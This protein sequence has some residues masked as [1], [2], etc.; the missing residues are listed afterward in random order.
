MT[1]KQIIINFDEFEVKSLL[2]VIEQSAFKGEHA[3]KVM[4][5]KNKLKEGLHGDKD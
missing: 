3:E 4:K 5:L 2:A 1:E